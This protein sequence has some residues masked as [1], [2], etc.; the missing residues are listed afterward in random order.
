MLRV[1]EEL[2][3]LYS[4]PHIIRVS[5][6]RRIMSWTCRTQMEITGA[7]SILVWRSEG[8][9]GEGR[10]FEDLDI[11]GGI[12]QGHFERTIWHMGPNGNENISCFTHNFRTA[13]HVDGAGVC[14][15]AE[16]KGWKQR[17]FLD[18]SQQT[19]WLCVSKLHSTLYHLSTSK[20]FVNQ[21][22]NWGGLWGRVLKIVR[23]CAGT[24]ER[25]STK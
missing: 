25:D 5:K 15:R 9:E 23:V 8:V 2:R 17:E 19:P 16:G 12:I 10:S 14:T 4:L 24:C 13:E 21:S 20:R 18:V 1:W 7:L 22:G 11:D 6:S 3:I